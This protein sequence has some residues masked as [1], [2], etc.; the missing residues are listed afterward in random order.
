MNLVSFTLNNDKLKKIIN[1]KILVTDLK[2][3]CLNIS[4]NFFVK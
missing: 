2:K 1:Y 4:K 3:D